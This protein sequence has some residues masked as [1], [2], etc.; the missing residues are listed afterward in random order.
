MH[1]VQ[2]FTSVRVPALTINTDLY[3]LEDV[4]TKALYPCVLETTGTLLCKS[5]SDALKINDASLQ[6]IGSFAHDGNTR[7]RIQWQWK[8]TAITR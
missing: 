4:M 6:N 5:I 1:D 8:T 2:P 3:P 7:I